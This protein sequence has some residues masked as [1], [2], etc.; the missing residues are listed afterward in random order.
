MPNPLLHGWF[1]QNEFSSLAFILPLFPG[2]LCKEEL[3]VPLPLSLSLPYSIFETHAGLP[4]HN[5]HPPRTWPQHWQLGAEGEML[6][7]G[8]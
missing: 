5:V 8:R 6:M 1:K 4:C 2:F 3:L 7:P